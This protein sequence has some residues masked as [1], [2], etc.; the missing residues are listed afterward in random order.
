LLIFLAHS[1]VLDKACPLSHWRKH[2][3]S[4]D[5]SMQALNLRILKISAA[6]DYVLRVD[7]ELLTERLRVLRAV[8]LR[9]ASTHH[10][11][12]DKGNGSREK[13]GS[14]SA[15]TCCVPWRVVLRHQR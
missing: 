3:F 6:R 11:A 15:E 4:K 14:G 9:G 12:P 1:Y 13:R 7:G 2:L 8:A 10:R 5:C